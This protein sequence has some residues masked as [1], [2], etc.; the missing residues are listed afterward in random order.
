[1]SKHTPPS[2]AQ[3]QAAAKALA[4]RTGITERQALTLVETLGPN[5]SSLMF[6]ARA[7]KLDGEN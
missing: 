6:H 3:L 4:N 1:M 2:D 5:S 7:L